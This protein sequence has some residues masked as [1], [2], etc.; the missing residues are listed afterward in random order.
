MDILRPDLLREKLKRLEG[1]DIVAALAKIKAERE[2]TIRKKLPNDK[3][4][5]EAIAERRYNSAVK[6]RSNLDRGEELGK[7]SVADRKYYSILDTSGNSVDHSKTIDDIKTTTI[8]MTHKFRVDKPESMRVRNTSRLFP[9]YGLF[10][11]KESLTSTKVIAEIP[12]Q[13]FNNEL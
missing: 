6:V 10:T 5:H 13:E 11:R 9:Q 8:G 1:E 3:D 7:S 4:P 2:K 12:E